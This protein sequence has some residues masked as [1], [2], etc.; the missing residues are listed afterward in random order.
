MLTDTIPNGLLRDSSFEPTLIFYEEGAN[1]TSFD[2]ASN[3]YSESYNTSSGETTF[4]VNI[5]DAVNSIAGFDGIL[6]GDEFS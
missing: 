3:F 5:S 2:L 1:T 6:K 4:V